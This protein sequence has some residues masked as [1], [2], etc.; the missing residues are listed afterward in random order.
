M[1]EF[2]VVII[3]AGTAGLSARKQ[4]AKKT[5]NYLVVDDG[6]LGTTCARVGC[7][8]SKVLIQAANDYY[9]KH[10]LKQ[11]G[12]LGG[13]NLLVDTRQVMKHVRSLRDRFTRGVLGGMPSW[14]DKFLAKRAKFVDAN[15]LDLQG[16]K[17]KAKN[18]IIATGS[19]PIIPKTWL[20]FKDYL[21]DTNDFFELENLP[22]SMAVIGMGVIGSEL[23]QALSRLGVKVVGVTVGKAIGGLTDPDIQ[24]YVAQKLSQE[25][26][27]HFNGA[28]LVGVSENGLLRI[29]ADDKIYEVEKA[30][31]AMGRRPN[32]DNLG[33]ENLKLEMDTKGVPAI[34]FNTLNVKG[35]DHI[36][37]PGDVNADRP[38]LHE[39]ADEGNIAGFNAVNEGQCFQ[40]R[41]S[42]GITF[43]DPNIAFVG[44]TWAQLKEQKIEFESGEVTFEGQ[45]RSIVK[46]KEQGLLRV[47]ADKRTGR[48]LGA[49]MQAPD[50]EHLAHLLA[51]SISLKLTVFEALKMPFY[52]PV[53]EEG[54]RTA[55][56]D[57]ACKVG[58]CPAEELLRCQDPPI[59]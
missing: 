6:P 31:V 8:P 14:Q 26:P 44:Q 5:D 2:D 18:I 51:W 27:L 20:E 10:K 4:V 12:I 9:R 36:Y 28:E 21:I 53:V 41:T 55:L 50:G 13:E 1:R 3:G 24:D 19:R 34:N 37:L 29:K 49:E 42:L 43:M 59:R 35:Y 38:I 56:R 33:L 25:M 57:L 17:V 39:A 15:I 58:E 46:L 11:M 40:R 52:H 32:V 47:Y 30:L 22:Q 54:L 7:M 16:E 23:G 45:G 48:L